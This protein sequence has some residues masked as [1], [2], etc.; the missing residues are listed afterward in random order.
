[1]SAALVCVEEYL[2]SGLEPEAEYVD[3]A[4]EERFLGTEPHSAWMGTVSSF[5]WARSDAWHIGS[6]MV[7]HIRVAETRYRIADVAVF[8]ADAV[9]ES[10]PSVPP[11]LLVEILSPEDGLGK[12][13]RLPEFEAMGVPGMYVVDPRDGAL[14]RFLQGRLGAADCILLRDREIAWAEIAETSC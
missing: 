1:M 6:R 3:G 14:F 12:V 10:I 4:V 5:F 2:R 11:L 8:D 7:L 9:R 13:L